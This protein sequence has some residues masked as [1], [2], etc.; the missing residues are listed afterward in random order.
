MELMTAEQRTNEPIV[1]TGIGLV[2]SLGN[3]REAVWRSIQAGRSN[4][5]PLRGLRGIPDDQLIG[6]TVDVPLATPGQLKVIPL[7]QMAAREAM[8]DAA[9][10]L[11]QVEMT[12]FG[13]AIAGHMGDTRWLAGDIAADEAEQGARWWE[14]FLPSTAGATVANEFGL[15]G[16]R[17]CHSTACASSLISILTA[18]RQIRDGQCDV[19]LTGGG[20][21]IDPLFAAGFHRMGVLASH[22]DPNQACRPFDR[23]RNGFV[24][25]EGAAMF[26][27]ER[28]SHA[29]KRGARI[30]AELVSGAVFAE[31][32]HVTGLDMESQALAQL[33]RKTLRKG[34]VDPE[35][36]GYINAH[37]TG[38]T[39]NDLVEMRAIRQAL[40]SAA[41]QVSVSAS[42][43]MIGHLVNAAGG[44][45][46][47]ITALAQRDGYAPPTINL[48]DLDPAC[49]LDCLPLVGKQVNFEYA[50]KLSVAFGGHLVAILMRRWNDAATG[51]AYPSSRRAA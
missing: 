21:A 15:L 50:I 45:E 18:M 25:G 39:Q 22:P 46:L 43:S 44:V 6:A 19:M 20:D 41:D 51:F 31:A 30:Y 9:I 40:G 13:S 11:N 29:L 24:M 49:T 37:G 12:R 10:D 2:T 3:D 36:I 47:A 8:Q 33:I 14:Q 23:G 7:C 1:I 32:H 42:K 16:P 27:V 4:V 38:T 5:R 34:S 26:V 35:D 48:K 28:L 17:V